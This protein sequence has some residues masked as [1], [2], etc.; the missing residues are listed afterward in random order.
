MKRSIILLMFCSMILLAAGG[1]RVW[2]Q[3]QVQVSKEVV[4]L[5][6]EKVILHQIRKG[7]T[8]YSIAKA[9]N[10]DVEDIYKL[11]PQ[12]RAGLEVNRTLI[13]PYIETSAT[14]RPSK[15]D[16]TSPKG[17]QSSNFRK[18]EAEQ[19]KTEQNQQPDQ[20]K[21][22]YTNQREVEPLESSS[23]GALVPVPTEDSMVSENQLDTT[24]TVAEFTGELAEFNPSYLKIALYLP[25]SQAASRSNEN[26]ADFYKGFLMAMNRLK[27]DGVSITVSLISSSSDVDTSALSGVNLIVGPV[28]EQAAK[29]VVEYATRHAIA[30][31]SPL[32]D[33]KQV[34]SPYLFQAAPI[35]ESKYDKIEQILTQNKSANLIM[36]MPSDGADQELMEAVNM[37]HKS[38]IVNTLPYSKETTIT[39]L[40]GMLSKT[41][42]NI[43]I[44]PIN[45]ESQV[46]QILSRIA[47]L[48]TTGRYP[49]KVIG[50]SSWGKFENINLDLFFKLSVNY[51]TSYHA[52]R[53]SKVI[54]KFYSDYA[55]SFGSI[56]SLFSFRGYDVGVFFGGALNEYG[57]KM[58]LEIAD[59]QNDNMLEVK[60][61]FVRES[62]DESFKNREWMVTEFMPDY[63]IK[64]K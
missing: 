32:S 24:I 27:Q 34:S 53:S 21:H 2:A 63:T 49:I 55:E 22:S 36:I 40:S 10:V 19:I 50:S 44:V 59:Y 62:L 51:V 25:L 48:N 54:R 8:V 61:R 15:N 35:K 3:Q 39:S 9:Y 4:R 46:E 58:P 5:G 14:T 12:T 29:P 57:A 13:I 33:F 60:Y 1:A 47:S 11:N 38:V 64:L 26:F 30:V 23:L 43:V 16:R 20:S 18:E 28:Y 6:G 56:P 31:V 52:D 37:M 42:E 17:G 7:Q 45:Q 41:A